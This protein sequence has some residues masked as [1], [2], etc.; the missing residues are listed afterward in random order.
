MRNGTKLGLVL[1][2]V[3]AFA[4]STGVSAHFIAKAQKTNESRTHAKFTDPLRAC[5]NVPA[6][7][8]SQGGLQV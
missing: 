2:V 4:G 6:D 5:G 3:L 7:V 1:I 8:R